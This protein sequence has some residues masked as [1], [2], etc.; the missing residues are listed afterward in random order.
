MR[1]EQIEIEAPCDQDWDAMRPQAGGRRRWCDHCER[2]VH[3][4]SRMSEPAA[5]AFLRANAGR[6][7]VAYLEGP[8]GEVTFA[9]APKFVAPERLARRS[10]PLVEAAK[11]ASA[12]SIAVLL[13]GCAPHGDGQV[14]R[15]D[16]AE[17]T[18]TV[19]PLTVIPTA[20]A[21]APSPASLPT[22]VPELDQPCDPPVVESPSKLPVKGRLKPR[23]MGLPVGTRGDPLGGI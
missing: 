19:A 10:R 8:S 14:I 15:L 12:A 18:P 5:R 16:D 22:E 11:L 9:P 1:V 17:A 23:R 4:L 2:Q 7:C 6:A 21:A 20:T 3:D 13:G